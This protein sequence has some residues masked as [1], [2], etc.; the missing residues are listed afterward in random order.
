MFFPNKETNP[1]EM[2]PGLTRR[3]L[4][5]SDS[6]MLAEFTF[7]AGVEVPEHAHPNDQVGEM[8]YPFG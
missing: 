1:V 5:T 7:E 8:K 4:A 6:M 3:V 2:L